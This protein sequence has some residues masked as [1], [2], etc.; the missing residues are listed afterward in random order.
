MKGK[1]KCGGK[2][3]GEKREEEREKGEGQVKGGGERGRGE[4][5]LRNRE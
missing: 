4:V 2:E 3:R 1:G 5:N